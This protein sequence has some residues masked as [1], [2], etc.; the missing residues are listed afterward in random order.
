M[1][2]AGDVLALEY[3]RLSDGNDL[4]VMGNLGAAATVITVLG[5]N[6]I[7]NA[8]SARTLRIEGGLGNDVIVSSPT[9]STCG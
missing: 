5:E 4:V 8:A 7:T 2:F 9:G 3:V 6:F 1:A